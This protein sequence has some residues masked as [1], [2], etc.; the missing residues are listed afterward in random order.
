MRRI[1]KQSWPRRDHYDF[2]APMSDPFYTLSFP[3]EVTALRNCCKARGLSFYHAM[4]YG[5]TKAMESVEAF[6]YKDRQGE[7]VYH[8]RL[9]PSFTHLES[10]SELFRIITLDAGD[11]MADFCR[12][13]RAQAA[14]QTEFITQGPWD[15]DALIYF[16]CLPWFPL[17]SLTNE[18]DLR[19]W[20]SIPRAAWGRWEEQGARTCLNLSLEL[21][22]RLLDGVHVGRFYEALVRWM[23]EL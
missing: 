14:A 5:V 15:E 21:N 16:T 12:R 18:K 22:H 11:D 17:T 23:E 9:V 7:I 13:T 4:V 10:G 19:P 2:F 6:H 3:V 8:E 20:D 1:D